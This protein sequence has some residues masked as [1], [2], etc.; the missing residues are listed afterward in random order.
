MF[1]H[2]DHHTDEFPFRDS[3]YVFKHPSAYEHMSPEEKEKLTEKMMGAHKRFGNKF[4]ELG[5]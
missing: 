1:S 5:S 4:K 3:P 2:T